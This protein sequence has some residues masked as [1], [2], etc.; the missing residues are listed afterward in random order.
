LDHS[1]LSMLHFE[2]SVSF[3]VV[4]VVAVPVHVAACRMLA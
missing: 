4:V 1:L 3:A 2:N